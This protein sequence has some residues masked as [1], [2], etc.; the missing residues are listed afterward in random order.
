MN[1]T[2][3]EIE[4]IISV[5]RTLKASFNV[6]LFE[7]E[8]VTAADINSILDLIITKLDNLKNNFE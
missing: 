4:I 8:K 5:I 3:K 1:N 2:K 7:E 6:A